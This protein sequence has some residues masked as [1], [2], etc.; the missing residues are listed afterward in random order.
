MIFR[1][2]FVVMPTNSGTMPNLDIPLRGPMGTLA[3]PLSI[4]N[5]NGPTGWQVFGAVNGDG[6]VG[7][8][9]GRAVPIAVLAAAGAAA[10]FVPRFRR[11][12][13]FSAL[14]ANSASDGCIVPPTVVYSATLLGT[15]A[16]PFASAQIADPAYGPVI[17]L[18]NA[19]DIAGQTFICHLGVAQARDD[20][21]QSTGV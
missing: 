9:L 18:L 4:A 8:V 17:R 20:D 1:T 5:A 3:L 10:G 19:P 13:Q 7:E 21:R 14:A 12:W 2:Y 15:V 6:S 11:G 16:A